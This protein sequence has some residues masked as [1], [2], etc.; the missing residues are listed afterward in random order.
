MTTAKATRADCPDCGPDRMANIVGEHRTFW[1][2]HLVSGGSTH[3]LL[4]CRGCE[5]VFYAESSWFSE[6]T[7]VTED[8]DTGEARLTPIVKTMYWPCADRV[9]RL[10]PAWMAKLEPAAQDPTLDRLFAEVYTALN[11]GLHVVTAMGIRTIF[12][13]ATELLE[14]DPGLPFAAKL[15]RLLSDGRIGPGEHS[16]LSVLTEAGSAAAH[17]AW[18]PDAEQLELLMEVIEHFVYRV[19]I[20]GPAAAK[21]REH[22]PSR[23]GRSAKPS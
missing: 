17:R 20:L 12:D 19:F 21:L 8:P 23:P 22:I 18:R 9:T 7:E 3:R 10:P 4:Q 1:E 5:K 2:E 15:E 13:R 14:V 16:I 6:D 11:A